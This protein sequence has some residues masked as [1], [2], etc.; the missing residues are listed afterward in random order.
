M[1]TVEY[2]DPG[3][4]KWCSCHIRP[5]LPSSNLF[6]MK[7]RKKNRERYFHLIYATA[8]RKLCIDN[9]TYVSQLPRGVRIVIPML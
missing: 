7:E 1:E 3:F 5:G 6:S 2:K 8:C 4:F 9:V